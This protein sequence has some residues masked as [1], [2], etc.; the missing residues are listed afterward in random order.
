MIIYGM[1]Y[2]F[3]DQIFAEKYRS[4][5]RIDKDTTLGALLEMELNIRTKWR[6]KVFI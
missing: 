6:I 2:I 5:D 4:P 1:G 3:V